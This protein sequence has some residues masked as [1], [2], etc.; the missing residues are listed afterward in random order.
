MLFFW[1][2]FEHVQNSCC[3]VWNST[4]RKGAIW[5]GTCFVLLS[6][7]RFYVHATKLW[8]QLTCKADDPPLCCPHT[9][10]CTLL[11]H[12]WKKSMRLLQLIFQRKCWGL[13]GED[14]CKWLLQLI[15]R[16]KCWYLWGEEPCKWTM[17]GHNSSPTRR[18]EANSA[19]RRLRPPRPRTMHVER[20]LVKQTCEASWK[21]LT[22]G[23]IAEWWDW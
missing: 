15:L 17:P 13:W 6:L 10:Q 7:C 9:S 2:S 23:F 16:S 1:S 20:L 5:V 12:S 18:R 8:Q 19:K 21:L 4:S 11:F 3:I 14:P 22:P